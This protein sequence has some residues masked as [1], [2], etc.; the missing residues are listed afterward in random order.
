MIPPQLAILPIPPTD[1]KGLVGWAQS[2]TTQAASL[3]R[4]IYGLLNHNLRYEDNWDGVVLSV[5]TPAPNVEF[6]ITHGMQKVPVYFVVLSINGNG[7]VWKSTT[8]WNPTQ[9]FLKCSVGGA[10]LTVLLT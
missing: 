10:N 4:A 1:P 7:A 2:L 3:L 8:P 5:V 9:V 6:A